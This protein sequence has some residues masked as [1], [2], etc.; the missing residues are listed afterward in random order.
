MCNNAKKLNM[1]KPSDMDILLS[2]NIIKS[3]LDK[4]NFESQSGLNKKDYSVKTTDKGFYLLKNNKAIGFY[5]PKLDGNKY[6]TMYFTK[7]TKYSAELV[8][9]FAELLTETDERL[10][11]SMKALK[12]HIINPLNK[13]SSWYSINNNSI[14]SSDT[15]VNNTTTEANKAKWEKYAKMLVDKKRAIESQFDR[16]K[17]ASYSNEELE[18]FS[19]ALSNMYDLVAIA[20]EMDKRGLLKNMKY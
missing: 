5:D 4:Q 10:A 15:S 7:D 19:N 13:Q 17:L 2:S 11:D 14:N 20:M 12:Q 6:G 8:L 18:K 3:S 16:H 1:V 9:M